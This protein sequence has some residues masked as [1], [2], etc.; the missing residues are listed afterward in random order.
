MKIA[1]VENIVSFHPPAGCLSHF[2][3][4]KALHIVISAADHKF[5][6]M[7]RSCKEQLVNT[8]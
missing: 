2:F 5:S 6:L 8:S 3:D 7:D 4:I 1:T